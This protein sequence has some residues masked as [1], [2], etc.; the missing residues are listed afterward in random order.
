[1]GL[2]RVYIEEEGWGSMRKRERQGKRGSYQ[3]PLNVTVPDLAAKV[4][5]SD[6]QIMLYPL[7]SLLRRTTNT[8]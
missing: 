4:E 2:I 1:M 5:V 8:G 3:L 7:Y 6:Q